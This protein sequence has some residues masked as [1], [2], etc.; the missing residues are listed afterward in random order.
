MSD[1]KSEIDEISSLN[2]LASLHQ[3][4]GD[5][6]SAEQLYKRALVI[7]E[8]VLG[9]EHPDTATSLSRLGNLHQ[10]KGDYE[11][12]EQLYKR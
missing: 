6:E 11:S 10:A 12:A 1:H 7:R 4:K 3:A 5:Y 9:K 8:K 2:S